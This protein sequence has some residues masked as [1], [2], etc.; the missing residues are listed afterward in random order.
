MYYKYRKGMRGDKKRLKLSKATK[1][2]SLCYL[3]FFFYGT[4]N[5][6]PNI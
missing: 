3:F 4:V 2:S 1:G 6:L 5:Y